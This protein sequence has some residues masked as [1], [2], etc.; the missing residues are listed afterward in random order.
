M[1]TSIPVETIN[2]ESIKLFARDRGIT[3]A[4]KLA[5]GQDSAG[6][7]ATLYA[8]V[9]LNREILVI[10]TNADPVFESEGEEF[11]DDL[12]RYGISEELPEVAAAFCASSDGE[13]PPCD[14]TVHSCPNC[15]R[16][17]QF[18][19]LCWACDQEERADAD[20]ATRWDESACM[21]SMD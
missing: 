9:G 6:N 4:R 2:S 5:T 21:G 3:Q 10:D 14:D 1:E 13:E 15:D 11:L 19:E 16:P 12:A 7:H 18:G 8:L 20:R 17:N